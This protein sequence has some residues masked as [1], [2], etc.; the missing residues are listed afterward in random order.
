MHKIERI[1]LFH[2]SVPLKASFYSSWIPGYPQ[3]HNRFTL[4]RLT[5]D[6]GYTG[7]SA[8]SAFGKERAG[9]GGLLGGYL[10]GLPAED[11]TMVRQHIRE[12]TYLGWRNWWIEAAFY[13]L[14]GKIKGKPV[15][16][17]L[18]D[19]E[20]TVPKVKVYASSGEVREFARRRPYLDEIRKMGF[21]AVKIRVKD[22][23]RRDDVTILKE[24][25]RYL[26]DDFVIGVDA[27]Q[28]WPVSIVEPTPIWDLQYAT[29]FGLACDDLG[30][31]WI[32]EPL[33]QHDWPGMAALRKR[34]KTPLSGGELHGDW[35]E[36][37]PLFEHECLDQYQPDATF[38]GGLTV[39]KRIMDECRKRQL[40]FSPHTWTNGIGLTINLHAMAAWGGQGRLEYPYEPPGWLPAEREGVIPPILVDPADGTIPVPQEPG[41]GIHLDEARLRKYGRRFH[42]T[43]P[44]RLAAA[45]IREKG[46][47]AALEIK[48]K[49]G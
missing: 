7:V 1:E 20:R 16:K 14:V 31:A 43:T 44:F 47:K 32:E 11:L 17:L 27:N 29:D 5:T 35:H 18:Q 13:D 24:C 21:D 39:S 42:V 49:K 8:G 15:Y 9:L 45:T 2:V 3:T 25:R 40:G 4:I 46:L 28:G 48:K 10:L 6:S 38:C 34:I 41:L 12:A 19:R 33:D 26:G 30:I 37:L 23:E 22:P 36:V